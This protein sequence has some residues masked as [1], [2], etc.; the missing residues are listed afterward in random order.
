M[1]KD[2]Y[3][4]KTARQAKKLVGAEIP[5]CHP[6]FAIKKSPYL[7]YK[8]NIAAIAKKAKYAAYA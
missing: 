5:R 6:I 7:R 8:T 4:T 2:W 1:I 3:K